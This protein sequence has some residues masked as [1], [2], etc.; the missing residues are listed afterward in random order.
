M[1]ISI[2][3]PLRITVAIINVSYACKYYASSLPSPSLRS[4]SLPIRH[5]LPHGRIRRV[6]R[7]KDAYIP[8][9]LR[10]L[11][12]RE[13]DRKEHHDGTEDQPGIQ[14]RARHEIVRVPPASPTPSDPIIEHEPKVSPREEGQ[15]RRRWKPPHCSQHD[16]CTE[17]ARWR[18]RVETIE[19][20][21]GDGQK[22]TEKPVPLKMRVYASGSE[23]ALGTYDAP[24]DA[25]GEESFSVGA[26]EVS[27]LRG[28]ADVLDAAKSPVHD[29]DL[30]E[31]GPDCGDDLAEE[32]YS[33]RDLHVVCHFQIAAVG[34][35]LS[36]DDGAVDFE[37]HDADGA[38]GDHEAGKERGED[39]QGEGDVGD[40]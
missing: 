37:D 23:H 10:Y 6:Q 22:R 4:K 39:V 35:G 11:H 18:A 12:V 8:P 13:R 14:R 20:V 15:R 3:R 9:P 27:G 7:L 17:H 16:G 28:G 19:D 25:G 30:D 36:E 34:L 1:S 33:R 38:T 31:A 32:G 24:D 21:E 29:C 2:S 26:G 40:G 5:R